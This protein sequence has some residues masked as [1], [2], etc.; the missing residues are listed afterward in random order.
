[1]RPQHLLCTVSLLF[2][3]ACG[4]GGTRGPG[5]GGGGTTPSLL[6]YAGPFG[7]PE[8]QHLL[9]RTQFGASAEDIAYV[10]KIGVEAWLNKALDPQP[11]PALEAAAMREIGDLAHP[12]Q[13]EVARYWLHM[14]VRTRNPLQEA[15]AFLW[16]DHFATSQTVLDESG[17]Y[18]FL[19]HIK[20]LRNNAT[21]N[22]RSLLHGIANDPAMLI[23]LDGV[24]ST[25]D[26]PNENF[27]REFFELF[28][29]G[30]DKGY[31]QDDIV[32]AA[33]AF[34]GYRLRYDSNARQRFVT[35]DDSR[36][37]DGV[38]R[39]FDAE[40][41]F[42]YR[43][44]VDL[45]IDRRGVAEH[46][47]RRLL[48]H[49]CH[50]QPPG[51][52]VADVASLLRRTGYELKPVLGAILRSRL[53]FSAESRAARVASPV[54]YVL[55]FIRTSG[56]EMEFGRL[57][58]SLRDLAQL[59]TMPPSVG[60][61]PE[62]AR[63]VSSA[64]L[65]QRGSVVHALLVDR[66]HQRDF[67]YGIGSLLPLDRD[68][69]GSEQVVD[70]LLGLMRVRP[71]QQERQTYVSW[72]DTEIRLEGNQIVRRPSPFLWTDRQHIDERLRGLLF[73]LAQHP[74][75]HTK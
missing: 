38:K 1:M 5:S 60:G 17:R 23:W 51:D 59:P 53:F 40:G 27:A 6:P 50:P 67:G 66:E 62:G 52:V 57:Y 49:F 58:D 75:A 16:H 33:R 12:R 54:E 24:T 61:W 42:G 35:W 36:H 73:L 71:T 72:L 10:Q 28:A 32:Q 25:K 3:T 48:S 39:V 34:T 44:L 68:Q 63:W 22:V 31:T 37:D 7:V 26:R 43:E 15:L 56:V 11:D 8:I 41:S 14:M 45:T 74:T 18:L 9:V 46:F 69:R 64:G 70:H 20:L 19:G 29:L 4:G 55:G 21:G 30:A 13:D 2:V 65:M 47:A